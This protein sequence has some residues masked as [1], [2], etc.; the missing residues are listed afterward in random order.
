M[1]TRTLA[2]VQSV[3]R[4]TLEQVLGGVT[5]TGLDRGSLTEL[6]RRPLTDLGLDSIS[7]VLWLRRVAAELGT[8][9]TPHD[10]YANPT[11][12]A[13][14][15]T[16]AGASGELMTA[17]PSRAVRDVLTELQRSLAA[18]LELP[19]DDSA[20]DV[21]FAELG[22]DSITGVTWTRTLNTA[23]GLSLPASEIYRHSTLAE[24]ADHIR[25]Q[26]AG[27]PTSDAPELAAT[28]PSA[29]PAPGPSRDLVELLR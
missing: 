16:V 10:V 20:T 15:A 6:D 12:T 7:C 1:T 23:F 3:L 27:S 8:A 29:V 26:T 14:A 24:L 2:E 13:L 25:S 19:D 5:D 4:A 21:P 22:V 28:G 9:P 11:I 18:E 17:E